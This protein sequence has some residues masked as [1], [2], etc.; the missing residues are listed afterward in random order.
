MKRVLKTM[1]AFWFI[2]TNDNTS[3]LLFNII[4]AGLIL[5]A[6]CFGMTRMV[7]YADREI[8]TLDIWFKAILLML[9]GWVI[10]Y[11]CS[12][13]NF[14]QFF[15]F[16]QGK[17]TSNLNNFL[18]QAPVSKKDIYNARFIFFKIGSIPFLI[19]VIYFLCLNIFVSRRE[20]ISTYL[21]SYSGLL[22]LVYCVWTISMSIFIGF[23]SLSSKTCKAFS[24]LLLVLFVI[25]LM[26]P[27][28]L[29]F[30][31][32]VLPGTRNEQFSGLGPTFIPIL[33]A[34]KYIGGISGLIVMLVS[35]LISYF[36]CCRL[37]LK[38]SEKESN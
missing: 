23:S 12:F 13:I 15:T 28:F 11:S 10:I 27:I 16:R 34:C 37:P 30:I 18:I 21:S 24:Y 9:L 38:I 31:P 8:I 32:A 7:Y 6:L 3:L 22:I 19:A 14:P 35:S 33:K 17:V 36:F 25:F 26:L 1:K 4:P 5:I 20:F 2:D 29:Q